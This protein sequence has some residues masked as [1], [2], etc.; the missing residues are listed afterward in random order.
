MDSRNAKRKGR[1]M[2]MNQSH[3]TQGE[4]K[5]EKVS[6]RQFVKYASTGAA[7]AAASGLSMGKALAADAKPVQ[8]K[9]S[10][11]WPPSINLVDGDNHMVEVIN[12]MGKGRLALDFHPAGSIV[13]TTELFDAVRRGVLDAASDYPGYWTGKERA[14]DFLLLLLPWE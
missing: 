13:G 7:L 5:G 3:T 4:N 8:W 6:R 9:V 11:C 12:K 1:G 10:T 14:L 2:G